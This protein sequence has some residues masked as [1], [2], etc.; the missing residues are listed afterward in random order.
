M[1]DI[2]MVEK[3]VWEMKAHCEGM[4]WWWVSK[5]HHSPRYATLVDTKVLQSS[6]SSCTSC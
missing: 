1:L 2:V 6:S 3:V 4:F 5:L